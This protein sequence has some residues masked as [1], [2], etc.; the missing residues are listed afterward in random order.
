MIES[1]IGLPKFPDFA[2]LSIHH[3]DAIDA[4]FDLYPPYSDFTFAT[5]YCWDLYNSAALSILNGN[6]VLRVE[7][8]ESKISCLSFLGRIESYKTVVK[9]MDYSKKKLAKSQLDLVP[10]ISISQC[11]EELSKNLEIQEERDRFD[12]IL[13]L[14]PLA[15]FA[16]PSY[17]S[18][19]KLATRFEQ[20]YSPT[21]RE[22]N[23]NNNRDQ[24]MILSAFN[25][26]SVS[27]CMSQNNTE[28]EL[29]ALQ[30]VFNIWSIGS[31]V[32]IGVI[33]DNCLVAFSVCEILSNQFAVGI[34]SKANIRLSGVFEFLRR[35]QACHLQHLGCKWINIQE[36]MGLSG[37]RQSKMLHHPIYFLRKYTI[38]KKINF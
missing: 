20:R 16:G 6:L 11:T 27:R 8:Y 1:N 21:V 35:T 17:R 2:H 28:R 14:Q 5:L 33:K 26:W 31:L 3:K 22:L 36:D 12:Y 23:L 13:D 19:H 34:F 10:E 29:S 37:L 15:S 30:R 38:R 18:K 24:A 32:A 25:D 4:Y 9:L 7:K